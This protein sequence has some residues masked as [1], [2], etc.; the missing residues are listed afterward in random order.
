MF[1]QSGEAVG[2]YKIGSSSKESQQKFGTDEPWVAA[3]PRSLVIEGPATMTIDP[4]HT[5]A[6]EGEFAFRLG[7]D[8][9]PR[10]EAYTLDE[11][12]AAVDL[13]A[14]AIELVGTRYVGGLGG[15]VLPLLLADG[16]VN[17]GLVLGDAKAYSPEMDFREQIVTMR[18]DGVE[19][20][21]GPGSRA[22]GD[23]LASLTWL[24]NHLSR[25]GVGLNNGEWVSTGTCTGLDPMA[26]GETAVADFGDL[27][28]VELTLK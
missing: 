4:A 5:P 12:K 15:K 21:S 24:A 14:G 2:G 23:P 22:L 20:G 17:E 6:L 8:L 25:A 26:V 28:T 1:A 16:G 27:G 18:V 19:K 9:P 10:D 13:V 11:V 3:I 7:N